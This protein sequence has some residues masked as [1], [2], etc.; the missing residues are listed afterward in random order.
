MF[1]IVHFENNTHLVDPKKVKI[2]STVSS[3]KNPVQVLNEL[4]LGAS[5]V[6]IGQS[7][8]DHLP[9]FKVSVTV[10]GR[11]FY[12]TGRSK[13]EA[14]VSAATAALKF[15]NQESKK[16]EVLEDEAAKGAVMMLNEWYPNTAYQ[17]EE[18][19]GFVSARFRVTAIVGTEKFVGM[20]T[21]GE[22]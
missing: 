6:V 16:E 14:N 10:G 5:F 12:G 18:T 2:N 15:I 17:Y 22:F 19:G 8:P 3:N 11:T 4:Y 7:G 1:N 13:K 20:G 21:E 9:T